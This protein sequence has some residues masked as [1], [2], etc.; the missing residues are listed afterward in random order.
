ML[1]NCE[2][3]QNIEFGQCFRLNKQKYVRIGVLGEGAAAHF[4]SCI[5]LQDGRI[6][7]VA[8]N[9]I[10]GTKKLNYMCT[11]ELHTLKTGEAFQHR[12][13]RYVV[14]ERNPIKTRVYSE[15][16][17]TQEFVGGMLVAKMSNI[18]L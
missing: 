15:S 3:A 1:F 6:T 5:L 4:V 16:G 13:T 11:M 8:K 12:N 7:N 14:L 2:R 18:N 9:V 17:V 10:V